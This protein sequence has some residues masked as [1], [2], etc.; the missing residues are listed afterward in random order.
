MFARSY[1][2][3]QKQKVAELVRRGRIPLYIYEGIRDQQE[4]P[5]KGYPGIWMLPQ[6]PHERREKQIQQ[7]HVNDAAEPYIIGVP[8]I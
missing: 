3:D 4:C 7:D 1:Q 6:G 8:D 5:Q 2:V